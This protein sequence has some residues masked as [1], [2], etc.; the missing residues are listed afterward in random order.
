[1]AIDFPG[2]EKSASRPLISVTLKGRL[3]AALI[4]LFRSM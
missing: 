2:S 3:S 4:Y 1:M